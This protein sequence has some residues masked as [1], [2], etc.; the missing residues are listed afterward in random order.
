[1]EGWLGQDL[2]LWFADR[3]LSLNEAVINRWAALTAARQLHGRPLDILDGLLAATAL[4]HDLKLATRN[5]KDFDR[6][7]LVVFNPWES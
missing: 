6:L 7:G 1:L 2:H 3:V 5:E 4:Q